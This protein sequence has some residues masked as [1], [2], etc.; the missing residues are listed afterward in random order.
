MTYFEIGDFTR[1]SLQINNKGYRLVTEAKQEN[2]LWKITK[3][4]TYC[5][6]RVLY[7]NTNGY[8]VSDSLE[9]DAPLSKI[10]AFLDAHVSSLTNKERLKIFK[11]KIICQHRSLSKVPLSPATTV[12]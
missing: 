2:G 7:F 9:I 12:A 11:L 5:F 8:I 10:Q 3:V 4:G 1:K 6:M